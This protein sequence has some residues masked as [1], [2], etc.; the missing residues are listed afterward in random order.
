MR[1]KNRNHMVKENRLE[2]T[3]LCAQALLGRTW[4]VKT[5]DPEM[6]NA[7]RRNYRELK[8]W[9]QE[10]CGFNLIFTRQVIKLEKVP[11]KAYPW[12]GFAEFS[13]PRDY[14]LFSFC[15]WYLEDKSDGEQFLLSEMVSAVLE[16][17]AGFLHDKAEIAGIDLTNYDH[18]LSLARALRK[19][20]ELGILTVVDGD[21]GEWVR[22]DLDI[23]YESSQVVHF[24]LRHFEKELSYYGNVN[25][26]AAGVYPETAEGRAQK[27]RHSIFRRLIQEPVILD[28][29]WSPEEHSYIT[30]KHQ[31]VCNN[32]RAISGLEGQRF[33]EGL[34]LVQSNGASECE[35][36]P[37]TK[38]VSDI[39]L[40]LA[41][42]LRRT[43]ENPVLQSMYQIQR[44]A[45][46]SVLITL[47]ALEQMLNKLRE[48]YGKYW[49]KEHQ[50]QTTTDLSG[51]VIAHLVEWKL[52]SCP[53][54]QTVLLSPALARWEGTYPIAERREEEGGCLSAG[55]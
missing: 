34:I 55:K 44:E 3:Q 32:L 54:E 22:Q 10:Y 23:L 28:S 13:D 43:Y 14:G 38:V 33:G 24:V 15:L 21:E 19:L 46:G 20:R 51:S 16:H 49:S 40:L 47:T 9:F 41:G 25:D 11:G 12:M 2:E 45:D 8:E 31:A 50:S 26:L 48:H 27:L 18:R 52:G 35:V 36:F 5:D 30:A 42:E 7:I 29:E 39:C 6:Y 53:D 37:T 1:L 4:V 17:I